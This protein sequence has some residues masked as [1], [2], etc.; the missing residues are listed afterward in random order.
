MKLEEEQRQD[1]VNRLLAEVTLFRLRGQPQLAL[2]RCRQALTIEPSSPFALE[3]QGDVLSELGDH[4][5]AM[6]SYREALH[7][8]P[9]RGELEEKIG[10]SALRLEDTEDLTHIQEQM[11]AAAEIQREKR[12]TVPGAV[13]WSLFLP[14]GGYFYLGDNPRGAVVFLAYAGLLLYLT[15]VL[16]VA[17]AHGIS[18]DSGLLGGVWG[19]LRSASLGTRIGFTIATA[20]LVAVYVFNILDTLRKARASLLLPILPQSFSKRHSGG[21]T[22]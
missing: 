16:M 8:S 13:L 22:K 17:A 11:A 19:G 12:K 10:I 3:A 20:L 14:G 1:E 5:E 18:P 6:K 9:E 4:A 15:S 7:I 21:T 2:E